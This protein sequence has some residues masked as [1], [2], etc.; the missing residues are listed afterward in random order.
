MQ[1]TQTHVITRK[2]THTHTNARTHLLLNFPSFITLNAMSGVE[3]SLISYM[4]TVVSRM[5]AL[6]PKTPEDNMDKEKIN[7][8][9]P[10][11]HMRGI[12]FK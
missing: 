11:P 12:I 6:S 3:K 5:Q 1:H 4:L 9:T 8:G 10:S 7:T 2:H